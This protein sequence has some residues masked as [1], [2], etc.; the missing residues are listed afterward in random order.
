ML[1]LTH[2]N[3]YSSHKNDWEHKELLFTYISN[4]VQVNDCYIENRQAWAAFIKQEAARTFQIGSTDFFDAEWNG[5]S[6][7]NVKEMRSL[8]NKIKFTPKYMD[9]FALLQEDHDHNLAFSL[10]YAYAYNIIAPELKA[11]LPDCFPFTPT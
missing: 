4:V 7:K 10:L 3:A 9:H 2:H 11:C 6:I 8:A 1:A 5:F